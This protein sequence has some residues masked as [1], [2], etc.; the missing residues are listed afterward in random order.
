MH[1]SVDGTDFDE[2]PALVLDIEG[3]YSFLPTNSSKHER[4]TRPIEVRNL[5]GQ[6]V[7]VE[8]ALKDHKSSSI[9]QAAACPLIDFALVATLIHDAH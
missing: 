8:A 9:P 1:T 3:S 2:S 4:N 5:A 7:S 6:F